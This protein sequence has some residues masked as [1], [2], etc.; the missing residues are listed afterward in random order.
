MTAH[1]SDFLNREKL[2]CIGLTVTCCEAKREDK[3][4]TGKVLLRQHDESL[5][6]SRLPLSVT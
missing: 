3:D 2:N 5:Y 4:S 6:L 1:P